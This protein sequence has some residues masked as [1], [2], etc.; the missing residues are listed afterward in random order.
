MSFNTRKAAEE[1]LRALKVEHFHEV[2]QDGATA[3]GDPKHSHLS[4]LVARKP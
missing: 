3:T 2:E 1:L 4:H